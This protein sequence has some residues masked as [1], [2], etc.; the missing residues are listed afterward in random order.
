MQISNPG[1]PKARWEEETRESPEAPRSTG[2]AHRCSIE[3]QKEKLCLKQGGRT[4][5]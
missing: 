4:K 5:P 2:L 3:Q 1:A